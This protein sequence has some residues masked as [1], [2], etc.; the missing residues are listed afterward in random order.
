MN[1]RCD[2]TYSKMKGT[3]CVTRYD[4]EVKYRNEQIINFDFIC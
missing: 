1:M 3:F 2:F 4:T